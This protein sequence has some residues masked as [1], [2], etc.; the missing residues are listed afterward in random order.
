MAN[1]S[2]DYEGFDSNAQTIQS[3]SESLTAALEAANASMGN[4]LN[5]STG[6]M[7]SAKEAE[8][9]QIKAEI[10]SRISTLN[11]LLANTKRAAQET[12]EYEVRHSGIA[13]DVK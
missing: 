10:N 3:A 5:N 11:T 9:A 12:N 6:Q 2:L 8:Y 1:K 4:T 7:V 13:T